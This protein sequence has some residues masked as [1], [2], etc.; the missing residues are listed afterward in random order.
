[1]TDEPRKRAAVEPA[2]ALFARDD[3]AGPR[4]TRPFS[5]SGG[6]ALVVLRAGGAVLWSVGLLREW[7]SIRHEFDL[8]ADESAWALGIVLGIEGLWAL[9]LLALAWAVWRGS[10]AARVLVM[11]GATASITISAVSYFAAGE[12]ITVRTTLLTLALDIL[13]LLALSSRDARTWTRRRVRDRAA[14]S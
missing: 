10:N 5:V 8:D 3:R 9:L 2:S 14:R 4:E 13:V 6:A 7:G 11:L 12:E 1:M